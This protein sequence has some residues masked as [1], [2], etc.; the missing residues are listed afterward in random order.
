MSS[1]LD[2]TGLEPHRRFDAA[3]SSYSQA[4]PPYPPEVVP[5]LVVNAALA[6]GDPVLDLAAGTGALTAPLVEAGLAVTA[7]E[8]SAGMRAVL[9]ERAPGAGAVDALAEKLPFAGGSFGLVTVANAWHWFDPDAAHAEIRR[10]LAPAGYLAVL[11]NV[12]DRSDPL[13]RRID[14]VKLQVLER[15]STPGPHEEEP[16]GWDRHFERVA[17]REFRF[18]HRPE[19]I[20]AYVASWSLVANMPDAERDRFLDEIRTWAPQG[21]VELPFRVTA[22]IGRRRPRPGGGSG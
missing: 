2:E 12:E 3:A 4:R 16:L 7:V 22:T 21:P 14:D 11:W 15:S 18:V 9:A 13:S 5:W 6:P 10:V 1:G 8:P 19:S 17:E 20:A